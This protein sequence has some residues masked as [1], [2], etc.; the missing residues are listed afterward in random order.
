M[1]MIRD[2]KR[3]IASVQGLHD[4]YKTFFK[5][6]HFKGIRLQALVVTP[7][8]PNLYPLMFA[9]M[10]LLKFSSSCVFIFV[11]VFCLLV[12]SWF[13]LFAH[14]KFNH[15]NLI[16]KLLIYKRDHRVKE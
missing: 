11:C 15:G 4:P 10:V 5:K 7:A 12:L 9:A 1:S 14:L 16:E 3:Y 8:K 13:A 6:K 2:D